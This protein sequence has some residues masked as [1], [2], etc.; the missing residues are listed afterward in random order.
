MPFSEHAFDLL[1]RSRCFFDRCPYCHH[2][3]IKKYGKEHGHHRWMPRDCG[4]M[5]SDRTGKVLSSAKLR[6]SQIR[7]LVS[8]LSDGAALRQAA[9]QAHVSLQTA[10]LWKRKMQRMPEGKEETRTP[11][12]TPAGRRRNRL[13][14]RSPAAARKP[15]A[16][17]DRRFNGCLPRTCRT[18][19]NRLPRHGTLQWL[20]PRMHRKNV[21]LWLSENAFRK[22]QGKGLSFS[23][24]RTLFYREIF[25]SGK[26]SED[27]MFTNMSNNFVY[28]FLKNKKIRSKRKNP[29]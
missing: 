19:F 9:H 22:E 28:P 6:P 15:G 7:R 18:W 12:K 14:G 5:F 24:Y 17:R 29:C 21:P 25:L 27:G 26:P 4:K 20:L 10:L 23:T 16:Y 13:P 1:K 2:N 3:H 11:K 8:M